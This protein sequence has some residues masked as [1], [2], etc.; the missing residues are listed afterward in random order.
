MLPWLLPLSLFILPPV[1]VWIATRQ[2]PR[3][4]LPLLA[5]WLSSLIPGL[6]PVMQALAVPQ[7]DVPYARLITYAATNYGIEPELLAA[8]VEQESAFNPVA[9]SPAG[10]MGLAQ[11]MP[12]T[13]AD[14]GVT[15]PFDPE[16]SLSGGAEYL[17]MMIG[18]YDSLAL[19]IAAYNAGPG[20]VDRCLCIPDNGETPGYVRR[21]LGFYVRNLHLV[22]L[23]QSRLVASGFHGEGAWPGRD[24]ASDCGTAVLSPISGLVTRKG[25]DHLGNTYLHL[26]GGIIEAIVMHGDYSPEVG[27]FVGKGEQIGTEANHGNSSECHTHLSIRVEGVLID[28]MEISK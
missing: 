21:V 22:Q 10:A 2:R 18:R 27:D 14:F 7:L 12:G 23:P 25:T 8:I 17:A 4:R 20:A 9:Q 3:Y 16:Q 19:A 13:A 24:Y 1:M 11:L 26:T 15:D 28:P 6:V 5:V